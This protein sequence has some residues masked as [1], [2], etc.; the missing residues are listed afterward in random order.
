MVAQTSA[1]PDRP[2]ANAQDTGADEDTLGEDAFHRRP[3]RG[4]LRRMVS[5][6]ARLVDIQ[7]RIWLTEAKMAVAK[8]VMYIVLFGAAALFGILG[9]IFLFIGAFH[10]LTDVVGLAPVWAYLI[11]AAVQLGLA[12]GLV[13]MAKTKFT[14]PDAPATP[15]GVK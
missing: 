9:T 4:G 10:V 7:Y 12:F 8:I 13:M 2:P 6:I 14:A 15:D 11:F 3:N 1:M 5:S